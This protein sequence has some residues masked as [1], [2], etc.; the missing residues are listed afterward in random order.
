MSPFLG[1]CVF[2][3]H[4]S[5]FE[6]RCAYCQ[7]H[8]KWLM[9]E[10]AQK[11]DFWGP[12]AEMLKF[13]EQ[14]GK[15]LPISTWGPENEFFWAFS[16]LSHLTWTWQLAQHYS[17]CDIWALKKQRPKHDSKNRI[18]WKIVCFFSVFSAYFIHFNIMKTGQNPKY[19]FSI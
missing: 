17:A 5:H 6:I 19:N 14:N 11:I 9:S 16:D 12:E 10:N 18:K 8:I 7:V 15:H 3:A 1:F 13:I 4:R 2:W